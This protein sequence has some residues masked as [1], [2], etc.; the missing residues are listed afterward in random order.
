VPKL[1]PQKNLNDILE[2]VGKS[3][4]GSIEDI[5][6]ALR[7][8]LPRRT[9]QRRLA[10]LE[11]AGKADLRLYAGEDR[12]ALSYTCLFVEYYSIAGRFDR[13]IQDQIQAG[14]EPVTVPYARESIARLVAT[15][16]EAETSAEDTFEK[17]KM[18]RKQ[19][20]LSGVSWKELR[21][22][23]RK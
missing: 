1:I 22:E 23:G 19:T 12:E 2:A 7:V 9:L 20:T 15:S 11:A 21:D 14:D 4:T 13:L 10:R 18:L 8:K 17:L 6:A 5:G 16:E 3:P